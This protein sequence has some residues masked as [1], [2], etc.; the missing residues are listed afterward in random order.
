MTRRLVVAL[1]DFK[2]SSDRT[3]RRLVWL[4]VVLV[5]MTGSPAYPSSHGRC[6]WAKPLLSLRP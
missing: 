3:A 6:P 1:R 4:T 5:V 2:A